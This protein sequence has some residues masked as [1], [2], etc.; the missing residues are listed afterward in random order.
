MNIL[1]RLIQIALTLIPIGI[2]GWLSVEN[3][4]P[5]GTFV[6]Q[7]PLQK[8]SSFIDALVPQERV[9][10][11][12]KDAEGNWFQTIVGDPAFF[13]VHPHRAFDT[14]DATIT[15]RN[16]NTPIIEFGALAA[17][18]P[19]RYVLEPLQNLMIDQSSW[20]RVSEG[21]MILLQRKPTYKSI[22]DFLAHP[23]S[24]EEVATYHADL[25]FPFRFPAYTA[26]KSPQTIPVSLRGSSVMKT[27][28]KQES[29]HFVFSYM[30]MNRDEGADALSILVTDEQGRS[31]AVSRAEDDGNAIRN[32][33]ASLLKTISIDTGV[34]PEGVYKIEVQTSRDVFIRSIETTQQKL[35]FLNGVYLGDETGYRDTFSPVL[36]WTEAKRLSMQTRHAESVQTVSIGS[37]SLLI[38]APYQLVTQS[39][40]DSGLVPVRVTKGDVEVIADAPIAFSPSQ[41]FRPDPV[42]LLPHT[43]LDQ[44]HVNY[45]LAKYTPPTEKDGWLT[46]TVHLNAQAL[47]LHKGSW[48]FTF[49]TP[50]IIEEKA[51]VDVKEIDLV[52][53]RSPLNWYEKV[54]GS[55]SR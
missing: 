11:L 2:L 54:V 20:S 26:L 41:Y 36:F 28:A 35:V 49:S 16:T 23:P 31:V 24:R 39:V 55:L 44:L 8:N 25:S 43:D 21:D 9:G 42:R 7:H 12:K 32:A 22:A 6:V 45:V 27:Y 4:I 13:F 46:A 10:A 33:K 34:L 30:D 19:E 15:F 29:L 14:V 52:M 17:L 38:P 37:Q 18:N 47:L 3:F 5:S 50:N 48:K 51:S 40:K 53:K 1:T